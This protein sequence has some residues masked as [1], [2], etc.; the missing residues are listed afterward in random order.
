M[1]NECSGVTCDAKK[2]DICGFCASSKQTNE[3]ISDVRNNPN[4]QYRKNPVQYD[5]RETSG[6][7]KPQTPKKGS[8]PPQQRPTS[9]QDLTPTKKTSQPSLTPS[10][11]HPTNTSQPN[12][13]PKTYKTHPTSPTSPTKPPTSPCTYPTKPQTH[14][15]QPPQTPNPNTP[16]PSLQARPQ[17]P[18]HSPLPEL[19]LQTGSYKGQFT[20][21]LRDGHG[22]M[23]YHDGSTYTGAWKNDLKHGK[24]TFSLANGDYHEGQYR[25]GLAWGQGEEIWNDGTRV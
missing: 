4:V 22:T 12:P 20:A 13:P 21:A 16:A 17:S 23:R 11:K 10:T 15:T 19:E 3:I 1:G 2:A 14:P 6:D 9:F 24:G 7:S 8:K 18:H 25:E 5:P